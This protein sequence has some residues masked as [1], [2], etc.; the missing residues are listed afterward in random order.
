MNQSL[1]IPA[2]CCLFAFAALLCALP[3]SDGRESADDSASFSAARRPADLGRSTIPRASA[4]D[5]AGGDTLLTHKQAER[6]LTALADE[7]LDPWRQ[8]ASS[9]RR[10][11]SRAAPRPIPS[12]DALVDVSPTDTGQGDN[13]V[14]ATITIRT[15][16]PSTL[17]TTRG[18]PSETTPT[19]PTSLQRVPCIVDRTTG[20]VRLFAGD[21]WLTEGQWLQLSPLPGAPRR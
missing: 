4:A 20:Q 13:V 8:W 15:G 3:S 16:S 17:A 18:R 5:H 2:G 7:Y 6:L 14:L 9:P 12:I 19:Q 11:Y 10:L 1:A 21:R